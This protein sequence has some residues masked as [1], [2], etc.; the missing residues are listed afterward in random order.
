MAAG[1]SENFEGGK[2]VLKLFGEAERLVDGVAINYDD[3]EVL[4]RLF[5]KV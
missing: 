1:R 4:K 2:I 5:S 3:F